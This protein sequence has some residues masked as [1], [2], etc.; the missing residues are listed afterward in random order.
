[1][2]KLEISTC[3][4]KFFFTKELLI[5]LIFWV[6]KK[7]FCYFFSQRSSCVIV[8]II[9][10]CFGHETIFCKVY[11]AIINQYFPNLSLT[12]V[13][14]K[15]LSLEL[16]IVIYTNLDNFFWKFFSSAFAMPHLGASRKFHDC[17]IFSILK[18]NLIWLLTINTR[19]G[20]PPSVYDASKYFTESLTR[21]TFSKI[22]FPHY[23]RPYSIF[24]VNLFSKNFL[25]F[26]PA[27][28][29]VAVK[30]FIEILKFKWFLKIL[31]PTIF[32]SLTAFT[33][34]YKPQKFKIVFL[35]SVM[36]R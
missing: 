30:N 18:K 4:Q 5:K 14:F 11:L 20:V 34:R 23:F 35:N 31:Y 15:N 21:R 16:K 32:F 24:C 33:N 1:M 22:I 10:W 27:F 8:L 26:V 28:S 36:P 2:Q 25:L 19:V 7:C 9:K 13:S 6:Q 29:H 17:P 12:K 3:E